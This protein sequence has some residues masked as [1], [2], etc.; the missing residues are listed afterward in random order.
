KKQRLRTTGRSIHKKAHS[1]ATLQIAFSSGRDF[2]KQFQRG[3]RPR[4]R[5]NPVF[6]W[7]R[8]ASRAAASL[9]ASASVIPRLMRSMIWLSVSPVFF[10]LPISALLSARWP[11]ILLCRNREAEEYRAYGKPDHG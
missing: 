5:W 8:V 6:A 2:R 7:F 11:F 10:S 9:S 3:R 4:T 1:L